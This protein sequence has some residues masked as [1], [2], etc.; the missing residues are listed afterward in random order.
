VSRPP[1]SEPGTSADRPDPPATRRGGPEP[2][3]ADDPEGAPALPSASLGT[4]AWRDEALAEAAA[5]GHGYRDIWRL[6]WPVTLNLAVVNV[7]SLLDIAMLGR[8]GASA[9]AAAGYTQQFYF[10]SSSVLFAVGFACVALMSR[11]I[12]AGDLA[13]ARQALAA[14]LLISLAAATVIVLLVLLPAGTWLDLLGAEPEVVELSIPYLDL[15]LCSTLPLAVAMTLEFALRADRD[16]RTPLL[17]AIAVST[18]KTAGNLLLIFGWLGFPR[19]ELVGAGIATLVSQGLGLL[20][21][22]AVLARRPRSS[23]LALRARDLAAARS[24]ARDVVRLSLPGLGERLAMNLALLAY[25]RVL[26]EYGTAAIA[27]YTVGI[28]I[29]SFSW[30]PGSGFGAAASTLVGQALGAGSAAAAARVGWRSLGL[31]VAVAVLLGLP[32]ALARTPLAHL[33]VTDAET[34]AALEPFLLCLAL[35][36]PFLQAHFALGGAHRG[37]GDTLTPFFAAAAG[38]WALRLP[39]ACL[40]AYAWCLD[41]TWVWYALL[42]DHL[43]RSSWLAWSFR[44]G[45]WRH[46]RA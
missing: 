42:F 29:L 45:R 23:P 38:N 34:V 40:F 6:A 24:A 8:L 28:R 16:T 27:A 35:A 17:V 25:F 20:I 12:G 43:T 31:S 26:A 30:L 15:V 44:R 33:F 32:C 2:R 3:A 37:A 5:P 18:V 11:A 13:R 46:A 39:L 41:L 22:A 9:M 36:Q 1:R 21:F 7:V 10:L 14:S 4:A 19:L